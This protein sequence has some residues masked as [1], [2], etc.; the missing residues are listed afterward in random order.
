MLADDNQ[1]EI[2]SVMYKELPTCVK[3][4]CCFASLYWATYPGDPLLCCIFTV[5][6]T[7]LLSTITSHRYRNVTDKSNVNIVKDYMNMFPL[8]GRVHFKLWM[9][10]LRPEEKKLYLALQSKAEQLKHPGVLTVV[11]GTQ[12]TTA[13]RRRGPCKHKLTSIIYT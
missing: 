10:E 1:W 7:G 6:C 3:R 4:S 9:G 11:S 5:L 12:Q 8:E 13:G 2:N